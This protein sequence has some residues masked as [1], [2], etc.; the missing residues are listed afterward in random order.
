[1]SERP[2]SVTSRDLVI[3]LGTSLTFGTITFAAATMG[4]A[5]STTLGVSLSVATTL[6]TF[7]VGYL[8]MLRRGE[9]SQSIAVETPG[10]EDKRTAQELAAE[11]SQPVVKGGLQTT[12]K[13]VADQ[14]GERNET[15]DA[16]TVEDVAAHQL[17]EESP[18]STAG[19]K[20]GAETQSRDEALCHRGEVQ[21]ETTDE[22]LGDIVGR[23]AA[24]G[25][26]DKDIEESLGQLEATAAS[27]EEIR[28]SSDEDSQELSSAL[29]TADERITQFLETAVECNESADRLL[30][31]G[32]YAKMATQVENGLEA[33]TESRTLH[34]EHG[35]GE[36]DVIEALEEDLLDAERLAEDLIELQSKAQTQLESVR[37]ALDA[38][39]VDNAEEA[40]DPLRD[41][42]EEIASYPSTESTVTK[43]RDEIAKAESEIA[44]NRAKAQFNGLLGSVGAAGNRGE[45]FINEGKYNRAITRLESALDSLAKAETIADQHDLDRSSTIEARREATETLLEEALASPE[46][47]VITHLEE[48]EATVAN[49]IERRNADNPAA[50]V[51]AFED[52]LERYD[53][54]LDLV[55]TFE[56][57]EQWEVEQRHSMVEEYLHITRDALKE[58][59]RSLH[60]DLERQL[61]KAD[62]ELSQAEQYAEVDDPVSARESLGS[63]VVN[64]D[65]ARQFLEPEIVSEAYT[66]RYDSLVDRAEAIHRE[67]PAEAES[68]EYR[69][70]D[71]VES[72]QLLA[73][74]LE[75]SPRPEFVNAYGE[76][77][78]E[79]YLE[80]FGSWPEALAAANLDP[81][82]EGARDRR[83]YSRAEVLEALTDLAQELGHPPS[84]GEMN[85]HGRM[86]ASPVVSRFTGWETALKIAGLT[87][88]ELP[89]EAPD[90]E[91]STDHSPIES[92]DPRPDPNRSTGSDDSGESRESTEIV[93]KLLTDMGFQSE[94]NTASE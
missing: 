21:G 6:L 70:R 77:P 65:E 35:L 91:P 7:T 93:D 79:A 49:G 51:E 86:S 37:R 30:A 83:E 62:S 74:Q 20:S 72:L 42:V 88:K 69:N 60:T 67:L 24:S 27:N 53:T 29:E 78:A 73:T 57:P 33:C 34:L 16:P 81:V 66:S 9:G 48:G 80:A 25:S 12:V 63:A 26:G 17:Q 47:D 71:L 76:H 40:L 31:E 56:L 55:T 61:D 68:G 46:R 3:V 89:E 41:T 32:E 43:Y 59:A 44:T 75:E 2:S 52:A 45:E 23:E 13:K 18:T 94:A 8:E 87:G 14:D 15:V 19:E 10:T 28:D 39:E 82:D 4:F 84:K 36:G 54:A 1:M 38:N 5:F 22:D 92:A 85:T 58:R 50:A 90:D 64:L 11:Q